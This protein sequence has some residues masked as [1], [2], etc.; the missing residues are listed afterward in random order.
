M[1]Q[2]WNIVIQRESL[3][4]PQWLTSLSFDQHNVLFVATRCQGLKC[5]TDA[6]L[7]LH[8]PLSDIL[9]CWGLWD[10]RKAH[11]NCFRDIEGSRLHGQFDIQ[12]RCVWKFMGSSKFHGLLP[13][14][15]LR[16][17]FWG[18]PL[19]T[20]PLWSWST[21]NQGLKSWSNPQS[22]AISMG[23][24]CFKHLR[25]WNGEPYLETNRF[26]HGIK[27]RWFADSRWVPHSRT[28]RPL[29]SWPSPSCDFFSASGFTAQ[30]S[31]GHFKN[32][33]KGGNPVVNGI[34][35]IAVACCGISWPNG[36][37]GPLSESHMIFP[38]FSSC[39]LAESRFFVIHRFRSNVGK[40]MS[41]GS[42]WPPNMDRKVLAMM[43]TIWGSSGA[44]SRFSEVCIGVLHDFFPISWV[45]HPKKIRL[46]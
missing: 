4:S 31:T 28:A 2:S 24:W 18:I 15:H 9:R 12:I 23:K 8:A 6:F 13:F 21:S 38:Y 14:S 25:A 29:R 19:W 39:L 17:L 44:T 20:N 3:T 7:V 27:S 37:N 11:G 26:F 34:S 33:P 5:S 32:G 16:L 30:P 43:M 45:P 22:M 35:I 41:H 40:V 10:G 36:K 42:E 1:V 46:T